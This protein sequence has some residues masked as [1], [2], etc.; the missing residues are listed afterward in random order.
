[1]IVM[2]FMLNQDA[3]DHVWLIT[4]FTSLCCHIGKGPAVII[5]K[6]LMWV[7]MSGLWDAPQ[8]E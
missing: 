3:V 1:M 2:L 4:R 6:I 7:P 5:E 8:Y